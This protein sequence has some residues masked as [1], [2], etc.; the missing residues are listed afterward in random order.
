MARGPTSHT[1]SRKREII[2]AAAQ[3]FA[4]KGY[5]AATLDDIAAEIGV[6]RA[7]LYY[8]IKSKEELILEVSNKL[9]Q[10]MA[11]VIRVGD[12]KL[13]PKEKTRK[14]IVLL[15]EN[16]IVNLDAAVAHSGH[17]SFMPPRRRMTFRRRQK[18]VDE[19][20]QKTLRAGVEEG[21]FQ[22]DDVKM[23][24][25]AIIGACNWVSRWYRPGNYLTPQQIA[26]SFI[27][28][29]EKGYLRKSK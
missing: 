19:V 3:I 25:F 29:F 24:A 14:I 1:V 26:D 23:T 18:K 6:T 7:A 12:S 13:S 20:F 4:V 5:R 8:Y 17:I 15:V 22:I 9:M 2:E 27:G 10:H 16:A 28:V 21:S 11:K